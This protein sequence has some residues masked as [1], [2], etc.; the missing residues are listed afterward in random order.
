MAFSFPGFRCS[1]GPFGLNSPPTLPA[2]T[3][4]SVTGRDV[5]SSHIGAEKVSSTELSLSPQP[6]S[7][8]LS[9]SRPQL[10]TTNPWKTGAQAGLS[11]AEA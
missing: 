5:D 1:I 8:I 4:S 6:T 7:R 2:E 9:P 11:P 10:K 3:D